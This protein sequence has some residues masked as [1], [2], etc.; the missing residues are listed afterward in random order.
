MA[1][2]A[3]IA[4]LVLFDLDGTLVDSAPDLELAMNRYL[5]E[6]DLP[7]VDSSAFRRRVSQGGRAMLRLT[8]AGED[9]D[10]LGLRLPRFLSIYADSI[11]ECSG[12]FDGM[13]EVLDAINAAGSRWGVV[14]NK[15]FVLAEKL[16]SVLGLDDECALLFGGDSL[17][18]RKP[19]PEPLRVACEHLGVEVCDA[20]YVGDDRRDIDA[21]RA[22]PM[23]SLA[24]AWGY[25]LDGDDIHSWGADSVVATPLGLLEDGRLASASQRGQ[26]S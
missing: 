7:A 2:N 15:P 25:Q 4:P 6:L 3:S 24:A 12:L 26:R 17:P 14:S 23:P 9:D 13:R 20:V 16:V 18:T 8:F 22:A 5:A 11:A 21:A 10:A 19:D 1:D